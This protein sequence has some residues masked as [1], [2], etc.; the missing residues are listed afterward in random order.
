MGSK[1]ASTLSR[2]LD[3]ALALP[4]ER[5]AQW[6]DTLGNELDA[7]K[8]RL[9]ALLARAGDAS[10]QQ[11]LGTLPKLEDSPALELTR[12]SAGTHAPGTRVGPYLL[13]R[14]LGVG[15]MGVVWLATRQDG[16]PRT[17][18]R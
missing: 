15:A 17:R 16:A 11:M 1:Q 14:R 18:L 8:P 4:P 13:T 9:R 3:A 6:L 10:A 5:R 7:L 2:L 12:F